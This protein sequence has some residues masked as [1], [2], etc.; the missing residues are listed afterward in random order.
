LAESLP[1]I[2][3]LQRADLNW[4]RGLSSAMLFLLAGL[5]NNISLFRFHVAGCA[6]SLVP[7]STAETARYVGAGCRKWNAWVTE[8]A[9]S[10]RYL[11]RKIGFRLVVSGLMRLPGSNTP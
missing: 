7:L 10:F 3:V 1:E 8:T 11:R 5:R 4:C 2:K 6:P 9:F